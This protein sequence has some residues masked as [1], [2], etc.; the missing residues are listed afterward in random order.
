MLKNFLVL[1]PYVNPFPGYEHLSAHTE[2]MAP[3]NA[4]I[5]H[6]PRYVV[7]TAFLDIQI[8]FWDVPGSIVM[9]ACPKSPFKARTSVLRRLKAGFEST[10]FF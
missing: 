5:Q 6:V 2:T 9:C 8:V 1:K 10:S 3:Y 7:P 4:D